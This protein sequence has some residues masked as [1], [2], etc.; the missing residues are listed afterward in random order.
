VLR[1]RFIEALAQGREDQDWSGIAG[2]VRESA[3]L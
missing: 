3:G 2:V 1:D